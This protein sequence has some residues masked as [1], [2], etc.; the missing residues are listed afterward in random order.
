MN[1]EV[2]AKWTAALR[3]GEY[4][5]TEAVLKDDFGFCCLGVLCDLYAKEKGYKWETKSNV[6]TND[7][8][9]LFGK[10]DLL[11]NDVI[12]WAELPDNSPTVEYQEAVHSLVDLNDNG[13]MK[14]PEIADL[15]DKSL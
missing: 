7:I 4:K 6:P 8:Y 3:S 14:F 11:P 1:K 2:K 5:Q 13:L 12:E 9:T 10:H 15:I